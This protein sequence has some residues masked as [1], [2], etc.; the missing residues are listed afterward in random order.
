MKNNKPEI[1][2]KLDDKFR[3][4]IKKRPHSELAHA[5]RLGLK[6]ASMALSK[7]IEKLIIENV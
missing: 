1:L 3:D 7:S 6:D 4:E 2:N 5:Y